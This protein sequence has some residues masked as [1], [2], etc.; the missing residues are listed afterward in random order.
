MLAKKERSMT[1]IRITGYPLQ[2]PLVFTDVATDIYVDDNHHLLNLTQTE[3]LLTAWRDADPDA[4]QGSDVAR[5]Y[6]YSEVGTVVTAL[7]LDHE[8]TL[9][10]WESAEGCGGD[11]V[12]TT[13][14]MPFDFDIEVL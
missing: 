9:T 4:A 10:E 2:E 8:L 7:H 14:Q 6:L 1:D 12:F 13:A 11:A 5:S 3:Q